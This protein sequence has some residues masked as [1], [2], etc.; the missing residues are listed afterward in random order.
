MGAKVLGPRGAVF[1]SYGEMM[2]P[3]ARASLVVRRATQVQARRLQLA[4]GEGRNDYLLLLTHEK[5]LAGGS[6][7]PQPVSIALGRVM[8]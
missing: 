4:A 2:R 7:P 3:K 8:A 5:S 1:S 6:R